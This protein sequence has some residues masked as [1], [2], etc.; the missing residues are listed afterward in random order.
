MENNSKRKKTIDEWFTRGEHDFR[1]ARIVF[2]MNGPLATIAILVQQAVEKYLK[3]FLLIN[4]WKLLKTHDLELLT[5][6][7]KDYDIRFD[8][9]LHFAR[10]VSGYYFEDR[11]PPGPPGDYTRDEIGE[12][13]DEA[14]DLIELITSLSE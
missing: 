8:R 2:D 7:A 4:G 5:T 1:S 6:E 3:G 11:Y 9:F 10:I 13:L 14:K 12:I